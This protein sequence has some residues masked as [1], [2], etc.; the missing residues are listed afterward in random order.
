MAGWFSFVGEWRDLYNTH[1]QG[2]RSGGRYLWV[3]LSWDG[4]FILGIWTAGR[5]DRQT[6][7][8]WLEGVLALY[9]GK[10]GSWWWLYIR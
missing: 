9:G 10:R 2:W 5:T 3:F 4:Q 6:T 7:G 1:K 8:P